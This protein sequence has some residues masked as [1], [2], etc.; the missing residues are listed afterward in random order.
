VTCAR[1]SCASSA[2][3]L[4]LLAIGCAR[5][6]GPTAFPPQAPAVSDGSAICQGLAERFV[7]LPTLAD[8]AA[9]SS[10]RPAPLAGR[11]WIRRCSAS[12]HEGELQVRLQ[13][14]G[15]YFVDE[16]GSDLSLRQQV[17]FNLGIEL[18]GRVSAE[19]SD[20]VFSFW[21]VPDREPK[22]ELRASEDL[23]VR[24]SSAWGAILRMMPLVS[25][26]TMAADRFSEAATNVL[27]S[28]LREGA[29]ATYDF[30]S[31]Q[32]DATLGKLGL[33]RTPERAFHDHTPWLVNDRLL[34]APSA[35]HVVG[36]IAPGPTR[37]DVN[38]EQG[39]GVT[40][41]AVCAQ[42]IE[43]NYPALASGRLAEIPSRAFVA[44]GTVNGLGPHTTDFR[45]SDCRFYLIVSALGSS[46]ST[47]ASLR[48]R[49]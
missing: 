17:P 42:D 13:G 7:G 5:E 23:D 29:T 31:G 33:G 26:R 37:L 46:L 24:A 27:R 8:P 43:E 25:V 3:A 35:L 28:K 14:P 45:V 39:T 44:T 2:L 22:V 32:S 49:A 30:G 16:N 4:A 34:L 47:L 9:D 1:R 36:P 6:A 15:W 20:G 10:S 40:Y 12:L 48:V 41:R 21:L 11:W 38:V 18:D 19:L